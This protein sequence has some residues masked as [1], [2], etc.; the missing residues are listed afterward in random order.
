MIKAKFVSIDLS[1]KITHIFKDSDG[2]KFLLV[3]KN[4]HILYLISQILLILLVPQVL[5]SQSASSPFVVVLDAGH[6][7][8]DT[9]NRGNGYYENTLL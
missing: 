3:M 5:Y 2:F 1:F 9:G 7:G 6:G 4:I 8:K